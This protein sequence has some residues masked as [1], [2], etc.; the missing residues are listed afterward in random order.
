MFF[1]WMLSLLKSPFFLFPTFFL[2]HTI[3]CKEIINRLATR[4]NKVTFIKRRLTII[5]CG[6]VTRSF[7]F[8][9]YGCFQNCPAASLTGLFF[10]KHGASIF[11]WEEL[12]VQ[13]SEKATIS[14]TSGTGSS[15]SRT[16]SKIHVAVCSSGALLCTGNNLKL[17]SGHYWWLIWVNLVT[18]QGQRAPLRCLGLVLLE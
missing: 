12:G 13:W 14:R 11:K 17:T 18:W 1:L 9:I 7:L 3:H 5:V 6:S 2:C 10:Y 16:G 15:C 8:F 4:K